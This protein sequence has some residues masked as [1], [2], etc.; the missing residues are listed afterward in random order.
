MNQVVTAAPCAKCPFRK[1][2]PIYLRAGAR[3]E[4]ARS[5]IDGRTFPCHGTVHYTDEGD[6]YDTSDST[7]CAGAAKALMLSGGTTQMMRIGERLG[8]VDLD[9]VAERGADVWS[10]S[11]WVQ[12]EEHSTGDNPVFEDVR[13]CNTVEAGCLAPAGYMGSGGAVISGTESA[14]GECPMCGDPVCSEC[15]DD[16]GHCGN[17]TNYR[18]EDE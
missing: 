4:I 17:C 14:D 11:E 15:A 8:L 13:A 5:L 12:L 7:Q 1:D 6:G 3:E 16:E 10:L 2:V 18:D 9:K